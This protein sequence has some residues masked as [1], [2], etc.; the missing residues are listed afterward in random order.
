M[1][2]LR[3]LKKF[4]FE[5]FT[6]VM[7]LLHKLLTNDIRYHTKKTNVKFLDF[8]QLV[9][10]L[11]QKEKAAQSKNGASVLSLCPTNLSMPL[12]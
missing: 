11:K 9:D 8:D 4:F 3:K 7:N 1:K 10:Q 12:S 6:Q 5:K 2:K